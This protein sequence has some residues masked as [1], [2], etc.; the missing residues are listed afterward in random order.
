MGVFA[1]WGL[2]DAMSTED[3]KACVRDAELVE[4]DV[5]SSAK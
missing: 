2:I 5:A 3:G 4:A 1:G